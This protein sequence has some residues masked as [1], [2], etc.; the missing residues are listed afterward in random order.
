MTI[1]AIVVLIGNTTDLEITI[2][3][4]TRNTFFQIYQDCLC[5]SSTVA[6]SDA[7]NTNFTTD[8]TNNTILINSCLNIYTSI[9]I[10]RGDTTTREITIEKTNFLIVEVQVSFSVK[11]VWKVSSRRV[12]LTPSTYSSKSVCGVRILGQIYLK[13]VLI[14]Q[15]VWIIIQDTEVTDVTPT[16]DSEDSR[17]FNV[18]ILWI[19][20]IERTDLRLLDIL[21]ND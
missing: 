9:W 7:G 11:N 14:N 1:K 15:S 10:V 3:F 2:N 12:E 13:I 8:R 17:S 5:T 20:N 18:I 4:Q 19:R 16:S 21:N 6:R